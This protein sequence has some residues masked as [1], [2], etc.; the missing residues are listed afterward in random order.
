VE[1]RGCILNSIYRYSKL[2]DDGDFQAVGELFRDGEYVI[3]SLGLSLAGREIAQFFSERL[4]IYPDGTP[5][6]THANPNI[7]LE[8]EDGG[9]RASAWTS[10]LVFQ[11]IETEVRCIFSGWYEDD[12]EQ[13][14][15]AW[16]WRRRTAY[17][18]FAG[19]MSHHVMP[20]N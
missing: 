6:T 16:T 17:T 5:H 9:D 15:D 2:V 11:L 19:D 13:V 20:A 8:V 3:P 14:G 12:F 7:M 1:P 10:V 18:R 4:K